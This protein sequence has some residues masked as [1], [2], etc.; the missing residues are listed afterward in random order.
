MSLAFHSATICPILLG[1][2]HSLESLT[3]GLEQVRA[4][5]GQMV[6]I[7]G[8]AGIGKSRLVT[9]VR[10]QARRQGWQILQGN[11]FEPDRALPYAPFLDLLHSYFATRAPQEI[12]GELGLVANE[13]VK[14]L[15]E[16][17]L[18]LPDLN[19]TPIIE[20]EQE[21][22]RLFH[23]LTH[24]LTHLIESVEGR[25]GPGLL[26]IIEDVHWSDRTSLEFLLYLA[27]RVAAHP[28]RLLLTYRSDEVQPELNHFLAD[29]DRARLVTEL[30]LA[31]LNRNEVDM[32][33]QA[34]FDL[35]RPG[36]A[37]FLE[38]IYALTEGN[39][40]FIEEILKSLVSSGDIFY[41]TGQWER[42]PMN[43][44]RIPRSVQAAVQR[45][46]ERLSRDAQHCLSL[47]AVAGRRFDF[48]LLQVLTRLDETHLLHV[49]RELI[50]A[51]LLIEVSADEFAFRHALTREA[52]YV[53]LLR[54]ERKALHGTIGE[55]L[56][57]LHTNRLDAYGAALA[58]HFY[59]AGRWEKTLE[60][61]RR[62]GEQAQTMYAPRE[63]IEQFSRAIE[64]A[65]QLSLPPSSDLYRARALA[66][67]TVG[68]FEAARADHEVA[69]ET[70]CTAADHPSEWRALLDL[71]K[72]WA[73]RDY[74]RTGDYYQQALALAREINDP[75]SLARS[76]NRVGNWYVNIEQP[77]E[78]L[79]CHQEALAIFQ[80]LN[81]PHG[82]AQ[83]F[84]LLG[85]ASREA[86]DLSQSTAYYERAV[87]LFRAL[88]DRPGLISSLAT[89]RGASSLATDT[90]V[91][92]VMNFTDVENEA[93]AALKMARDIGWRAGEAFA[94]FELAYHWGVQGDYTRAL[95]C[96]R[97][98][99]TIAEEI[100]HRQWL[101]AAHCVLG[102]LYHD[103]LA[104]S[105]AQ[106]HLEQALAL[107]QEIG[108][109]IW[110]RYVTASLA[111]TYV[112]Q[113]ALTQAADVLDAAL[114]A[115]TQML[116]LYQRA[117]WAARAELA[118]ARREEQQALDIVEGLIAS[119][120]GKGE[121]RIIPRLWKLR[122]EALAA[123]GQPIEAERTLLAARASAEALGRRALQWRIHA[124]LGKL[125]L[126]QGRRQEADE[127][128]TAGNLIV[129]SLAA[130]VA[131]SGLREHFLRQALTLL[132]PPQ[133][134]TPRQVAKRA[135]DGLTERERA[136]AALIAQGKSNREIAAV[137]V[138]SKRTVETHIGNI[139]AKLG[140][141]ARA[142]IIVWAI[143]KGLVEDKG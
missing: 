25:G 115:D 110:L 122:G 91:P 65:C 136:V 18:L 106:R 8:E 45:R 69:R 73:S 19:P 102:A 16:L 139:M 49:L 32:M 42:K 96:A 71:G 104:L 41:A 131:D 56:E 52:V 61:S 46:V 64:A 84:D 94:L 14:L 35:Q 78:G 100:E 137:M 129:E 120:P 75:A 26:V 88:D 30:M 126:I 6:L 10:I 63:A 89:L 109:L 119:A 113:G 43:E 132:P 29:L 58:Y 33:L 72:L 143:E 95:E 54:R 7:A 11:C 140:F 31:H 97:K 38:A 107:A 5:K 74:A 67:E 40:F 117:C 121:D 135:F 34:I 53:R 44:L 133:P 141:E 12:R 130:T 118:L 98:S 101:T 4:G 90:L 82:L 124:T 99:L 39:P 138:L 15:P 23:A 127:Q 70:A 57:R 36:R 50:E 105:E 80:A 37:E 21:K 68:D 24:F 142:Q 92:V 28:I 3:R 116:T 103:F 47:A 55:T 108:S 123:L 17:A 112:W 2:S 86:A 13:L 9:E 20:L 76:L 27:R 79:C 128:G 1:R 60:Y 83:T 134:L 93:E 66:Y 81:D 111:L 59:Q 114:G 48:T 22:R 87:E 51:Q 85:L 125:Y 62:A 77:L